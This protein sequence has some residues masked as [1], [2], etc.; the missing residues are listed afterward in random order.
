MYYVLKLYCK[1]LAYINKA[2]VKVNIFAAEFFLLE[3]KQM[4][5]EF[6]I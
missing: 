4:S 2:M 5:I 6:D 3:E 1:S